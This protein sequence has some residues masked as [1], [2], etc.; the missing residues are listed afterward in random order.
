[1]SEFRVSFDLA[2]PDQ[3]ALAKQAIE[4]A[5]VKL[6]EPKALEPNPVKP[7][8]KKRKKTQPEMRQDRWKGIP[9]TKAQLAAMA[10]Q[11]VWGLVVNAVRIY[12]PDRPFSLKDLA[13]RIS[14]DYGRIKTWNRTFAKSCITQQCSKTSIMLLC[15]KSCS[16]GSADKTQRYQISSEVRLMILDVTRDRDNL[17]KRAVVKLKA[18]SEHAESLSNAELVGLLANP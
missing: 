5:E 4:N 7:K 8:K 3:R 17:I 12:G 13:P 9:V 6:A 10:H 18:S 1:M 15:P 14:M 2:D 11:E 16:I